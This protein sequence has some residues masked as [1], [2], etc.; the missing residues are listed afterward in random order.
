MMTLK[1]KL[2]ELV[3]GYEFTKQQE[4]LW[5]EIMSEID[6][7]QDTELKVKLFVID[8]KKN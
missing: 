2:N 5:R 8:V 4:S 1:E 3:A 7:L 6:R